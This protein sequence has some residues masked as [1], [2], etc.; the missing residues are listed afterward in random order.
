MPK[1]PF[2]SLLVPVFMTCQTRWL[3]S[4]PFRRLNQHKKNFTAIHK[5]AVKLFTSQGGLEI[6]PIFMPN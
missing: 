2:N 6:L 4:I 5:R 3:N 1:N